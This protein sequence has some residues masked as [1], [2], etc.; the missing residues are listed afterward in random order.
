MGFPILGDNIYGSAPR[1]GGPGLHL[2]AREIAV[3]LYKKRPPVKAA[4]PVPA[5]MRE[6]LAQCGWR[7]ETA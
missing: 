6:Q 2:H 1:H 5:H 7:A 4:A 3:P